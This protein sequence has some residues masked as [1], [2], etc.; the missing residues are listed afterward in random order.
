MF[1]TCFCGNKTRNFR[2]HIRTVFSHFHSKASRSIWQDVG[3]F[4]SISEHNISL[5]WN[6][7]KCWVLTSQWFAEKCIAHGVERRDLFKSGSTE[8]L[9][10]WWKLWLTLLQLFILSA[11]EKCT[12]RTQ[13]KILKPSSSA[14]SFFQIYIMN[15]IYCAC[16][17]ASVNQ[18]A[19]FYKLWALVAETVVHSRFL[20]FLLSLNSC[21]LLKTAGFICWWMSGQS[22]VSFTGLP[23]MFIFIKSTEN[24]FKLLQNNHKL[25]F[26]YY[27]L[28]FCCLCRR[29][30]ITGAC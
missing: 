18:S 20:L 22:A 5:F 24:N 30:R 29:H 7:E 23:T 3:T 2:W 8:Q 14:I 4:S 11:N 1:S 26:A 13:F 9:V 25:T 6:I 17:T 19:R 27:D 15:N 12:A 10:S 28:V 16:A 21:S